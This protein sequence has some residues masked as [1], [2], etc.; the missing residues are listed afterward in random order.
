MASLLR[1]SFLKAMELIYF[2]TMALKVNLWAK[3]VSGLEQFVLV[4]KLK[5]LVVSYL[6]S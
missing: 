3:S 6:V 2:M 4:L 1:V 5:L